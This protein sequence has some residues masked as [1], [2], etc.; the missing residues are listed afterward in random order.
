MNPVLMTSSAC[1]DTAAPG[2][3]NQSPLLDCY[4]D[5]RPTQMIGGT[6]GWRSATLRGES[7]LPSVFVNKVLLAHS[8]AHSFTRP[9]SLVSALT[10]EL[11]GCHVVRRA[12]KARN[13]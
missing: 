4:I 2:V 11:S 12:P 1:H 10:A 8:H 7:C 3:V 5:P 9:L 13:I 6:T